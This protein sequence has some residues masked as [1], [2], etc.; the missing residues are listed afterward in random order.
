MEMDTC[1]AEESQ[2]DDRQDTIMPA[3]TNIKDIKNKS[4]RAKA[5]V[6]MKRE[7][8]KKKLQEA[9]EKKKLAAKLG[10]NAPA[11]KQ[12]HTIESLREKDDTMVEEEDEELEHEEANDEYASYFTKSYVPKILITCSDNPHTKTIAFIRELCRIIPGAV[13]KWR[14]RSSIKKMVKKATDKGFT[15]ILVVN[16]DRR[17]PNGLLVIHLPEGP[18]ALFRLSNP[19]LCK[20]IHRDYNE[21]TGHRPEVILN[22]FRTRLGRVV[23]RMLGALFHYDPEFKGR[24]VCTFHNQRDYIFFRH[25]R[26]EFKNTEKVKLR[27]LGPR[28]TLRLQWIQQGA[29]DGDYEWALKRHEMETSRRRF[30]L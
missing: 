13:P 10:K 21:I 1:T 6:E 14:S 7:K 4:R 16:E 17:I 18:S 29:F 8:R 11:K 15:D 28:F 25:H 19:K 20:D 26:Y 22:N 5:F 3:H 2:Q 12:P 23:A 27:E 24:R 30:F 9:K